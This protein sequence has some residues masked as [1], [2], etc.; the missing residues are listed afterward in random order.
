MVPFATAQRVRRFERA[1]ALASP[2]VCLRKW[3]FS[4]GVRGGVKNSDAPAW[5]FA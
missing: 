2:R 4:G 5:R 1:R 3:A